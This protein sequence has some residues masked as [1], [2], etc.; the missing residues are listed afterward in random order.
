MQ[1]AV[2]R[3]GLADADHRY[4]FALLHAV[5]DRRVIL[6]LVRARKPGCDPVDTVIGWIAD[7]ARGDAH[8]SSPLGVRMDDAGLVAL[9]ALL[10]DQ[11]TDAVRVDL[12]GNAALLQPLI[13]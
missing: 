7:L 10:A 8:D 1:L 9:R 6:E 4:L 13:D 11:L 2:R 3:N 5:P 12:P